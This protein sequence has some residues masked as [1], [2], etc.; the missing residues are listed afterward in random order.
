M[1][2]VTSPPQRLAFTASATS[3]FPASAYPWLLSPL[4]LF[5]LRPIWP[6]LKRSLRLLLT[7]RPACPSLL[8]RLRP[9]RLGYTA[10]FGVGRPYRSRGLAA[11][12]P[13]ACKALAY[14]QPSAPADPKALVASLHVNLRPLRPQLRLNRRLRPTHG[15]YRLFFVS[16]YDLYGYIWIAAFGLG[17][18]QGRRGLNCLAALGL[19]DLAS[20]QA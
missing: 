10:P 7:P 18:S 4:L 6:Q 17:Q 15:P 5:R 2:L 13:L 8:S 16:S 12:H 1:V 11:Y 9:I 14:T 19:Y 20:S 3:Q